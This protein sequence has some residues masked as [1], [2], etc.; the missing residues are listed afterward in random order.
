MVVK[1][2]TFSS[3]ASVLILRLSLSLSRYPPLSRLWMHQKQSPLSL[4]FS[5]HSHCTNIISFSVSG[6]PFSLDDILYENLSQA[7]KQNL[8]H[9]RLKASKSFVIDFHPSN[10]CLEGGK[11]DIV[12]TRHASFQSRKYFSHSFRNLLA[13]K[14]DLRSAL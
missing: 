7:S 13:R 8:D 3:F 1:H 14:A 2:L 5:Q 9:F 6:R 12:R 4:W 11:I 10:I